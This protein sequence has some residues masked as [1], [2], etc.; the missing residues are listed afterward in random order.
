V[1]ANHTQRQQGA[2]VM[3]PGFGSQPAH[4]GSQLA[5]LSNL[6]EAVSY[7]AF[8]GC[9]HSNERFGVLSGGDQIRSGPKDA[10]P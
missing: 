6:D 2:F 1:V 7:R 8:K 10:T 4:L 5:H 9:R 3:G